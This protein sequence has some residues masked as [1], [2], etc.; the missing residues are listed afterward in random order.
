M[1]AK[2]KRKQPEGKKMIILHFLDWF[3]AEAS[4]GIGRDSFYVDVVLEVTVQHKGQKTYG[5]KK[6]C[7]FSTN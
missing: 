1:N 5:K 3:C 2:G 7:V 6:S 4:E